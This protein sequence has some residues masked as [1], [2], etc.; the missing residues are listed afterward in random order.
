MKPSDEWRSLGWRHS[1]WEIVR[2][3]CSLR[4]AR[5]QEN[6]LSALEAGHF[7]VRGRDTPLPIDKETLELAARYLA[8]RPRMLEEGLGALRSEEEAIPF[9]ESRGVPFERTRTQSSDHH[10]SSK[11]LVAAVSSIAEEVTR[12]HGVG[13]SP[14]RKPVAC[15]RARTTSTLPPATWTVQFRPWRT[16]SRCWEVKEYWGQTKGGS[17][18]SDAVYECQLVGRELREYEER[19]STTVSHIVFVDGRTQWEHRKSDLSRF[20]DLLHQGL[21]DHLVLGQEV[22][23]EWEAL[24]HGL[25]RAR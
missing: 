16:R 17:K 1:V 14:T 19:T 15:G 10:Q 23:S 13:L 2:Y 6:W 20:I 3:Y 21:I 12:L 24:L 4:G 5:Q 25:L 11:A 22:E 8:E 9:C 7:S 18:M